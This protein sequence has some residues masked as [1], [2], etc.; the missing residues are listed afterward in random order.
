MPW[1]MKLVP[2][3]AAIAALSGGSGALARER[4]EVVLKAPGKPVS[5]LIED[6]RWRCQ[7]GVCAG[8]VNVIGGRANG[9]LAV[10]VCGAVARRAGRVETFALGGATMSPAALSKCNAEAAE[11]ATLIA[12]GP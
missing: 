11:P 2:I 9:P 7:G 3:A 6:E 8:P 5:A 4:A 12:A 1:M 10:R